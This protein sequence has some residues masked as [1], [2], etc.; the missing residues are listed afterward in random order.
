[1]L[2]IASLAKAFMA[3]VTIEQWADRVQGWILFR[4]DEVCINISL[5]PGGW[6]GKDCQGRRL[7]AIDPDGAGVEAARHLVHNVDVL[8]PDAG[9]QTKLALVGA[10]DHLQRASNT[11][12]PIARGLGEFWHLAQ[13]DCFDVKQRRRVLLGIPEMP[14]RQV[15]VSRNHQDVATFTLDTL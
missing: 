8:G 11:M 4:I 6:L 3:V 13:P 5:N 7:A 10:L 9:G 15:T 1:M 12:S 2:K 14:L